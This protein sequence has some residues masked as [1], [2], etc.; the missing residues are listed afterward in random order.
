MD[1][2]WQSGILSSVVIILLRVNIIA[3]EG[4]RSLWNYVLCLS[5]MPLSTLRWKGVNHKELPLLQDKDNKQENADGVLK[6]MEDCYW[7]WITRRPSTNFSSSIARIRSLLAIDRLLTRIVIVARPLRQYQLFQPY[8]LLSSVWAMNEVHW[9]DRYG[10]CSAHCGMTPAES[11]VWVF[12]KSLSLILH[13]A[14]E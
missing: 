14:S 6:Q 13:P 8:H 5:G 4:A 12:F 3:T 2:T 10:H 7:Y 9:T 1:L 11:I